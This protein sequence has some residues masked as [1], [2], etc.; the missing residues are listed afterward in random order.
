MSLDHLEWVTLVDQDDEVVGSA[1]KLEAHRDGVLHRAFSVFIFNAAGD[2]LLQR[3]TSEKYHC[4]GLWS[5]TACGHPRPGETTLA[6]AKRRL[7]E[8]MRIEAELQRRSSFIYRVK[9]GDELWEHELDH[10][11]LGF[12]EEDPQAD[13]AEVSEWKWQPLDTVLQDLRENPQDFTPWFEKAL[14]CLLNDH[15]TVEVLNPR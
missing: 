15:R 14:E 2:L 6:A 10:V 1:P 13:P 12:H 8:E 4:G 3:R 5:N 7:W 11:F 9:L